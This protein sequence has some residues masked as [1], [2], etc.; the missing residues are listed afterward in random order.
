MQ[1]WL[2][3][4]QC[5]EE[6]WVMARNSAGRTGLGVRLDRDEAWKDVSWP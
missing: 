6:G 5:D 4:D 2:L 1:V 3:V